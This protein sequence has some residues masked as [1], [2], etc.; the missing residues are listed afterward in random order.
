MALAPRAVV[1]HRS[2]E[3][4]GLLAHHGTRGQAEF[5]LR[6]RGRNIGEVHARHLAVQVALA[7][8]SATIPA[9]WRRATV[10]RTDLPSFLFTPE[11]VVVI[12]GQDGLVANTA[13]YLTGQ[14]V[15]GLDPEPGRNAGVLVR[16][17]VDACAMLLSSAAQGT[18]RIEPRTMASA[19]T[20]DGQQLLA[21]NEIYIGHPSH[22]SA[23]YRL[24]SPDRTDERQS[25]SGVLVGTGTG[26]TGWCRSTW[27][28]RRSELALPAPQQPCLCWFVRE[29][30]P[31]PTTGTRMTQG[32]LQVGQSL[33]VVCE[34]D[35]LVVFGDGIESDRINLAWGQSVTVS[36]A[37]TTL[38]L[39]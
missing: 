38:N 8:V 5:F 14:P 21:L 24:V 26:A 30:W 35:D 22:Q 6:S 17:S 7:Q 36:T 34:S 13:K 29:A 12:V 19:S 25:S 39:V 28:E 32:L 3:Y 15:I 1:V 37:A 20:D 2:T 9:D 11:D 27:Q 23:R 16:H 18:A 4:E 31:S 10:E 33:D